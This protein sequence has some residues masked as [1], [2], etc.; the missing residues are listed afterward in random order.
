MFGSNK[1]RYPKEYLGYY[2][3]PDV[4]KVHNTSNKIMQKTGLHL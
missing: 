2:I 1:A 4:E 3:D